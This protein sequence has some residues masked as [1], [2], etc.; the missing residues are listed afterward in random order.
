MRLVGWATAALAA[1]VLLALPALTQAYTVSGTSDPSPTP[2]CAGTVCP[3]LR[4]AV[5]AANINPGSTIQL[6]SATYTL[7]QGALE[8]VAN[9]TITGNGASATVI[10]QT[11]SDRVISAD[12]LN[13][14]ISISGLTIT[15]GNL[16]ASPAA[17]GGVLN[18]GT[19]TLTDVTISAN[20]ATGSA[21]S[22]AGAGGS[23]YGGAVETGDRGGH[24]SSLTLIRTT[25]T[26]NAATGGQGGFS[27]SSQAGAGGPAYGA[28]Y[29]DANS[30]IT[31]RDSRVSGNQIQGGQGGSA[32]SPSGITGVGGAA[33][34]AI[35]TDGATLTITGSTI[36][37]NP[38]TGG[39]GGAGIVGP[40]GKAGGDAKGAG[41]YQR[42]GVGSVLTIGSTT[43]SGN[44]VTGGAG[45]FSSD[46][47]GGNGG[48]GNGGAIDV[49]ESLVIVNSTISGN[50]AV[51]GA[52]GDGVVA[53][54]AGQ[55][56]DGGIV[57][58]TFVSLS[59]VT[60]ANNRVPGGGCCGNLEVK[61]NGTLKA[62][63]T[64]IVEGLPNNCFV[65]SITDT[66]HNLEDDPASPHP[67]CH[68]EFDPTD[69]A[70]VDP[71]ILPLASNGGL[72]QTHAL[73][74]FSPALG[75]GGTCKDYGQ[76]GSPD[77]TV[78]QRGMP[79]PAGGCDIGAF[80]FQPPVGT[81]AP[82]VTGTPAAGM[83]LTC[84]GDAWTGDSLSFADQWLRDGGPI[85]GAAALG[86][87]VADADVGH[88]LACQVT[89]S[90]VRGSATQTSAGVA[91]PVPGGGGGGQAGPPVITDAVE[92]NKIWV[93]G[94]K[95]ARLTRTRKHPVGTVF[96]FTLSEPAA[97]RLAF[98]RAMPGRKVGTRCVAPTKRNAAKRRC[99][100]LVV[101]GTLA[102]NGHA[103][104]DAVAFAGRI[105]ASRRLRLGR[106]TLS[107]TASDTAG[108]K[109]NPATLR[110]K[111]A[112]R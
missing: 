30:T 76:A 50:V 14:F 66:G 56:A 101:A 77:L 44:T 43:I 106:Y 71:Q 87:T 69:V 102:F 22:G 75:A 9:M 83:Q 51:R 53:G 8:L 26:D 59:S 72:T 61:T 99:T 74:P 37:D 12:L 32:E 6:D 5:D 3:S 39:A 15:G 93:E 108:R 109:S 49:A 100:R 88:E 94:R 104:G 89:A 105:S 73:Q 111:I 67:Q 98:A 33:G 19:M 92:T 1:A 96:R 27:P 2:G 48:A 81:G 68:F 47:N 55:A 23:A 35:S 25:I 84:G 60:L 91:V 79:R 54:N 34:G 40:T 45:G 28:V 36:A 103:G 21:G 10:R 78:D 11:A 13:R 42:N 31:V 95:L 38:T 18:Y 17:G 82:T 24:S 62:N 58:S 80:Q 29:G 112:A 107:I 46:S 85:P 16:T 97:V 65:S 70:G 7:S 86:Y 57:T 4:A 90:N 63:N 41:I 110:F 20:T 52:A 64:M